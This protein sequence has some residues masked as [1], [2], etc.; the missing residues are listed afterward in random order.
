MSALEKT[1]WTVEDYLAFE[2]DSQEKHEFVGGEVYLMTGASESHNL[3]VA[4]VIMTLGVQL[5]RRPCRVYPSDMLVRIA[6]TGDFHYPDVSVVCGEAVILRE[7]RDILLNPTVVIEVLSPSTELYDRGRKFHNYRTL[8]SLQEYLLITQDAY[9]I[10]RFLRH[11]DGQWL[12]TDVTALDAVLE[13]PSIE[14]K[15]AVAD[16]YDKVEFE[17]PAAGSPQPE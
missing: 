6:A 11:A 9:R 15:L 4:N 13:L 16:V 10:E 3:I 5:R 8:D 17:T 12:F 7:A 14:C 1:R 2:R